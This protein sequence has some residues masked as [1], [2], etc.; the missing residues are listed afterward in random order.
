MADVILGNWVDLIDHFRDNGRVYVVGDA[1][2]MEVFCF[3]TAE[4]IRLLNIYWEV[5][6]MDVTYKTTVDH[7]YEEIIKEMRC[8]VH[9]V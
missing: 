4:Q 6:S 7:R 1:P 3:S 2:N 9:F 8:V 5:I